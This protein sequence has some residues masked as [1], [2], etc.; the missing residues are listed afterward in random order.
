[1]VVPDSVH[2]ACYC[3][4]FWHVHRCLCECCDDEGKCEEERE[5]GQRVTEESAVTRVHIRLDTASNIFTSLLFSLINVLHD[6]KVRDMY[7][8]SF[9]HNCLH[10]ICNMEKK[11]TEG[12]LIW[13][14]L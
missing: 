8:Q 2:V 1:M 7:I 3:I 11:T 6:N 5:T 12:D 4:H 13:M 10:F 9:F 14:I